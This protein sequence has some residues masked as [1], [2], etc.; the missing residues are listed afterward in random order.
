MKKFVIL[1]STLLLLLGLCACAP[2]QQPQATEPEVTEPVVYYFP[3]GSTLLGVDISGM[4]REGAW[5]ALQEAV[6][7][8]TLN[9]NVDGTEV[10][11]TAQDVDLTVSR[12]RFDAI[13]DGM[14]WGVEIDY[15]GLISFNEG[16][17]RALADQNFNQSAVDAAIVEE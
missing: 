13:A 12:E 17:L 1:L 2:Q 15:T 4:E 8:Y 11:L 10:A 5:A 7:A 3:A 14:E 9:L 16:K 6:N